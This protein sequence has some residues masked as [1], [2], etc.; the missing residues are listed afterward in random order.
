MSEDHKPAR[1]DEAKRIRD[2][3]GFVINNRV[4]GELAVSRAFGDADFKKGIKSI[5]E[6]E[7]GVMPTDG[8]NGNDGASWDQPLIIAE[9]DILATTLTDNDQ[10]LLL[11]C[12][13]LFDVFTPEEVVTFVK[14]DMEKHGDAQRCCQVSNA[15]STSSKLRTHCSHIVRLV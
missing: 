4:M 9:P 5:I 2:A 1:E 14:A 12:D 13:G 6:E 8:E 15:H 10:F 3:G 11:A 7:G